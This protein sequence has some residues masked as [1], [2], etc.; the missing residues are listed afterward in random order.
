MNVSA[1][2]LNN[3]LMVAA[4]AFRWKMSFNPDPSKQ[5]QQVIY[6]QKYVKKFHPLIKFNDLPI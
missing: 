5:V 2:N 1:C 3:D 4:W 6:S